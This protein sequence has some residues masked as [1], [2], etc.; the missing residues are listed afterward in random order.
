MPVSVP[1]I[2]GNMHVGWDHVSPRWV[3][4]APPISDR[5]QTDYD[6]HDSFSPRRLPRC[7]PRLRMTRGA[8]YGGLTWMIMIR[9]YLPIP[10]GG[11][12]PPARREA[13]GVGHLR[14]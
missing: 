6:F 14:R 12:H 10:D 13:A 8:G 7:V 11:G 5:Q 9:K 1:V 3:L 4:S 2:E